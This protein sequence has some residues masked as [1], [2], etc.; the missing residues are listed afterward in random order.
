MIDKEIL[1][2]I[3]CLLT[4]SIL[5]WYGLLL[6]I[7]AR[8]RDMAFLLALSSGLTLKLDRRYCECIWEEFKGRVLTFHE[9]IFSCF[10]IIESVDCKVNLRFLKRFTFLFFV[11]SQCAHRSLALSAPFALTD[12]KGLTVRSLCVHKAFNLRSPFVKRSL[13]VQ[14]V[15]SYFHWELQSKTIAI[16]GSQLNEKRMRV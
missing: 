3:M 8:V 1:F 12:H 4:F 13:I 16:Y 7:S 10:F 6:Y 11:R 14:S 2:D 15:F 5:K 9:V